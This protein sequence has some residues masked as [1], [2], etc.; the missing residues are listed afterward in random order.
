MYGS[1]IIPINKFDLEGLKYRVQNHSRLTSSG[2]KVSSTTTSKSLLPFAS[3]ATT[4]TKS[5]SACRIINVLGYTSL[6]AIPMRYWMGPLR[7]IS[8]DFNSKVGSFH[9]SSMVV[10]SLAQALYKLE[11]VAVC[12]CIKSKNGDPVMSIMAPYLEKKKT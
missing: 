3:I 11:K 4:T 5:A 9:R 8:G 7:L 1:D 12:T 10:A 6:D 2:I